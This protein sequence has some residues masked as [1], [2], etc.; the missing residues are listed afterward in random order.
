MAV[1]EM[2]SWLELHPAV[3]SLRTAVCD[4]NGALRGKR[5]PTTQAKKALTGGLRMP[6]S[7]AGV[8]VWGEDI[9]GGK[10]VF[11]TGDADGNCEWTGRGPLPIG[12]TAQPTA[13]IPLWLA[14]DDGAPFLGDPRRALAAIVARYA[15]L[16]LTPVM[17]AELEFYLVDPSGSCPT[18]PLSPTSG[19]LLEFRFGSRIKRAQPLRAL[20]RRCLRCLRRTGRS[21]RCGDCRKR[22]G[23]IRDQSAARCR[24]T[25]GCRR[26]GIV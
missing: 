16:G 6:L 1:T 5:I 3:T 2:L 7:V 12:W 23:A 25:E 11:E 8:D 15:A 10:L 21:G 13:L 9:V 19:R 24:P 22:A 4:L 18:A 20:P 14:K 17:A 26:C